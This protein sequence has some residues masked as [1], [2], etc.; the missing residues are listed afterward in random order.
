MPVNAVVLGGG[1][2]KGIDEPKAFLT[3]RGK[4]MLEYVLEALRGSK[5]LNQ[6]VVVVPSEEKLEK[7]KQFQVEGVVSDGSILDNLGAGL[8]VLSES[9]FVLVS[10]SDIPFVN[11]A[12]VDEFI[13]SCFEHQADGYY[14][15]IPKEQVEKEFPQT[16]RTYATLREGTFTGGNFILV[17]PAVFLE[18]WSRLEKFYASRKSPFKLAQLLGF[19]FILKFLFRWLTIA[20]AERKMSSLF[21]AKLKAII[22]PFPEVGTDIDKEED[23]ALVKKL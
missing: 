18:N 12:M 7:V 3:L 4:K 5:M 17:K 2:M 6:I 22:V 9:D 1:K 16:K 14:P 19:T 13:K 21:N 20:D 10:S 8:G 15:I 11:S 23:L